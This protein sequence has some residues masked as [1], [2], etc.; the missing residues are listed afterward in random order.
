M[1]NKINYIYFPYDHFT[2]ENFCKEIRTNFHL[3]NTYSLIVKISTDSNSIFKMAGNQ[4]GINL[5]KEHDDIFYYDLYE[6]IKE[7]I[8]IVFDTY[9]YIDYIENI[10]IIYSPIKQ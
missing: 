1:K 3:N 5:G 10:L 4:I 9:N 6:V 8:D 7:R 2:K